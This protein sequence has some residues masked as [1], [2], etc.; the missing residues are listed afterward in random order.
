MLRIEINDSN[1]YVFVNHTASK[2]DMEHN[3]TVKKMLTLKDE[4]ITTEPIVTI[5]KLDKKKVNDIASPSKVKKELDQSNN[6]VLM[7]DEVTMVNIEEQKFLEKIDIFYREEKKRKEHDQSNNSSPSKVKKES[8]SKAVTSSAVKIKFPL[9]DDEVFKFTES[10]L[11]MSPSR[12]SLKSS[13]SPIKVKVPIED[14]DIVV[15]T[16]TNCALKSAL[17]MNTLKSNQCDGPPWW[18]NYASDISEDILTILKKKD[19]K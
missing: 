7:I 5:E 17:K 16:G 14:D 13:G 11:V 12:S 9:E 8:D 2:A 1:V 3:D 4:D 19:D 15:M 10:V 18:Y 6:N